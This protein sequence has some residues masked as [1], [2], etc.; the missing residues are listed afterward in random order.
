MSLHAWVRVRLG[1]GETDT[2]CAGDLIGRT[3]AAALHL[4][5]PHVSEAHAMLSLRGEKLWL[6]A[7]RRRFEVDG[8]RMDAVALVEGQRIRLT[9]AVEMLVEA[10]FLPAAVVGLEGPGLPPQALPGTCA[11]VFDPHPRLAPGAAAGAAAVFWMVGDRWRARVAEGGA[12]D[13]TLG[14]SLVID[15]RVWTVVP[16]ALDAAGQS[17]TRG[18]AQGP[19]RLVCS[20][21]T[22]RIHRP[23]GAVLI[24]AGQ[25]AR[26][27]SELGAVG[28]PLDWVELAQPHWPHITER[29]LLRRRWDGL[30]GRL[31]SRLRAGGVRVDLVRSTRVGLVELV[32]HE[33]DRL[34]DRA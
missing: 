19:L 26:V 27:V 14:Q 30:L 25:I 23:D 8:R 15:G 12:V 31:R 28:Q 9:A 6:L 2:L 5:D 34:E 11:L 20:F 32:L 18:G 10:V 7:L 13:L 33:G 1:T 4:D 22:V 29:A 3:P 24:L 21:D 17:H 16:I